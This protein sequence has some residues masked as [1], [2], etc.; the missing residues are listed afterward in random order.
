MEFY[1]KIIRGFKH[2]PRIIFLGK[3]SVLLNKMKI[4]EHNRAIQQTKDYYSFIY[5][6]KFTVE[7]IDHI[8]LGGPDNVQDW[9]KIK[10]KSKKL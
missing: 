6:P 7:E 9:T 1:K 4:V 8:N 10:L 5:R 3:R 2:K